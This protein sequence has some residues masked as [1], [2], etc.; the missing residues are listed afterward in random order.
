[1]WEVFYLDNSK[2][3]KIFDV[4]ATF[5]LRNMWRLLWNLE[6]PQIAILFTFYQINLQMF[7]WLQI[8]LFL[9]METV[10]FFENLTI[11]LPLHKIARLSFSQIKS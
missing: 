4:R 3:L 10:I 1:M 5:T 9:E 11:L 7:G 6:K 2:F 8:Y